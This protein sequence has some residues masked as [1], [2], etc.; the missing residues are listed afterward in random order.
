M[1]K[2]LIADEKEHFKENVKIARR[3]EFE[4]TIATLYALACRVSV[5]AIRLFVSR[6][7]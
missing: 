7:D 5:C 6:S 2:C 3:I 1:Y 4:E